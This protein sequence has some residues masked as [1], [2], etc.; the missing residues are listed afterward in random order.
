MASSEDGRVVEVCDQSVLEVLNGEFPDE[1]LRELLGKE[2]IKGF[3]AVKTY[4]W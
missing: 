1:Q 4:M 2:T 3:N